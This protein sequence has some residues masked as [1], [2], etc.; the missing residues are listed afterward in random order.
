[1]SADYTKDIKE[2]L[3]H[4][5]V[6]SGLAIGYKMLGKQLFKMTPPSLSKFDVTDTAKLVAIVAVSD[7]TKEYLVKQKIIPDTI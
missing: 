4:G 1:M 6:V 7:V 5:A 2:S 3:Y